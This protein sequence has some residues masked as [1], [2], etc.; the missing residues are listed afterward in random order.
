MVTGDEASVGPTEDERVDDRFAG[1]RLVDDGWG[2]PLHPAVRRLRLELR[3]AWRVMTGLQ[4]LAAPH[5]ARALADLRAGLPDVAGRAGRADAVAAL[6]EIRVAA[7]HRT[8]PVADAAV[9][10]AWDEL[11]RTALAAATA[12]AT[13]SERCADPLR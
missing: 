10:D 13:C 12:T 4:E 5:R 7:R 9:G 8:D 1:D 2:E 11:I 3:A 6:A